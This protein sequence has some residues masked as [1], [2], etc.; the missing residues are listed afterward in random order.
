VR[1]HAL[2]MG[3]V[4]HVI[5]KGADMD[6]MGFGEMLDDLQGADFVAAMGRKGQAL[7]EEQQ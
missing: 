2:N 4:R 1:A 7:G 5:D 6:I 3:A